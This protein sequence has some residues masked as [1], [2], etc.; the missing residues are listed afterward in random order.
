M[1]SNLILCQSNY[2]LKTII[3]GDSVVILKVEQADEINVIFER[4][5]KQI[6]DLK[7]TIVG[8]KKNVITRDSVIFYMTEIQQEKEDF[9][10]SIA[11]R[12]DL[13]ENWLYYSSIEGAWLYYSYQDSL[14]Y[15]V[16]LSNYKVRKDNNTGDLYFYWC[17]DYDKDN[18]VD[19]FINLRESPILNWQKEVRRSRRPKVE[20]VPIKQ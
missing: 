5:K 19:E 2:P 11:Q 7:D 16:D 6:Q 13:I 14:I 10:S 20:V 15:R 12:L 3:K 1:V 17:E 18:M 8:L 4:Q 9:D